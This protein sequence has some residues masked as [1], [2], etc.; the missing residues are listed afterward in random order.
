MQNAAL[1]RSFCMRPR[2]LF[3]WEKFGPYHMDRCEALAER[4]GGRFEILGVEIA[5]HGDMYKWAPT[6][7]G[8]SFAKTTLFPG[9]S[10]RE[11]TQRQ[12]FRALLRAAISARAHTVFLCGYHFPP[13]F[14]AAVCLRLLGHTVVI[15][16]DSK[17]DDKPRRVGRE[18]VKALLYRPYHAAFVGSPR[19]ASYLEFL[20]MRPERIALGYDTASLARLRRLA[21]CD[22]APGGLPHGGRH[23]TVIARF[24]PEKNL[25]LALA[26]YAR[27]RLAAQA[28][29]RELWLCGA[30]RFEAALKAEVAHRGIAGVRF[31]GYLQEDGI[32]TAL[33][34][35][36]ALILPSVEEPFG[37]VVNEALALGVPVILSENC[38]AR[39]LLVRTAVNGYV[40]EP[41]NA[42]GLAHLMGRLAA[43]PAEWAR[44]AANSR[45]FTDLA[46]TGHF[47]AGVERLLAALSPRGRIP[48][49]VPAEAEPL[50]SEAAP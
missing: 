34:S 25:G 44:L 23:F 2:L 10:S 31:M 42:E 50:R 29:A 12:Y 5:S 35:S 1:W 45:A 24:V 48:R 14:F 30:G 6:G 26:A 18:F 39:D 40:V 13:V 38:G 21:G 4:L 37:L 3:V 33:A 43:E 16:N 11:L 7:A 49:P 46:D 36:L 27:Y 32:A 22:P 15:M 41:D 20:G 17:F 28:P 8:R 47:V 9:R 19:A